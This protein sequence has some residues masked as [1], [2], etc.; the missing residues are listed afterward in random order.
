MN[1]LFAMIFVIA[2]LAMALPPPAHAQEEP[3]EIEESGPRL[4]AEEARRILAEELAPGASHQQQVE[5]YLRRE[6]AAFTVGNAAIRID[7]LRRLVSLTEAP[8]KFSPYLFALWQELW[9]YGNQ[10]EAL[11]IGESLVRHPAATPQ[12]RITYTVLLGRNYVAIGNR[13]RGADLLKKVEA[14]GK[15]LRDTR[16]PHMIA[17]TTIH[18]EDLRATVLH[19]QGDPEG[20]LAAIRRALE[21]SHAEVERSRAAAGSS[22]TDL[23]YDSAIR[24]RNSVMSTAVWLYFAQG[25]NEEAEGTARIG[26]RLAADERTG[27]GTVGLWHRNL[28]QALLG[29][30]RFDEAVAAANEALA[31]LRASGAAESSR[32]IVNTQTCQMQAL[33]GLERWVDADRLATEMRAATADDPKSRAMVDNPILQAFLHLKNNRLG[34]AR[35]RIDG[36]VNYRQ[37]AY[38]ERNASTV[39]ARAVR[40]LVLQAQGAERLALD[41]YRAVFANVFAPERTFGDAQPAGVR[42]FYLPQT[43]RGFLA[44]VRERYAKDGSGIDAELVDLSFRV[45]DRLQL[46]AVQRTLIDSAARVVAATPELQALVRREQEQRIKARETATTLNKA[47]AEDQRLTQEAKQRQAAGKAAKEDEKKLAQEAAEERERAR[48]RQ[49]ALKQL[50]EQLEAVD[51]ERGELQVEIGRRFP[52]YQSLVNPKPPSFGE[53]SKLL[54]KD[55]AFVSLY[56]FEQGTFVWGLGAGGRPAFHVAALGAPEVRD[57]V[58]QL[59]ATLDLSENLDPAKVAFD[60][61]SS[62]RL[63]RELL[64]PVWPALGSPRVVTIA[65][66]GDLGQLPFAVLMTRPPESPFDPARAGWLLRETAVN[67]IATAAAFRAL[68]ESRQRAKPAAA[69]FGFGDPLFKSAAAPASAASRPWKPGRGVIKVGQDSDY[70]AMAALP[71][72]RDEILAIAKALGADPA[73]DA[74]FGAQATRAAAMTTNLSDRRVIAFATHGLRPGDLPGLSRPAL[75][76]AAGAP[77]ESPLLVLDDVLTIKL[78]ADWIVLSA[79]NTAS[80]DGRAQ[81]AFSGLARA[82]FFAGARSALATHWAVES[83]SA[84]QLVTR[85]FAHQAANRD[86]TRAESLRHAQ[87]ELINGQAGA[88]YVHPFFWAPYALYGDPAQ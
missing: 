8:D 64:L 28:A 71:E 46:S 54:A 12:Q 26:L 34:Q 38:G 21:A 82:F 35:E 20:A 19:A 68:R 9:R 7:S 76:M 13:D 73:K 49:D 58:T 81:E 62:H 15:D 14:E 51:K 39:E 48:Q 31:V 69:L 60:A 32:Y 55:E 17:Y 10:T 4:S 41:D 52:E 85:T 22:R 87:L 59:R 45:A 40:A 86:A 61:A 18:T 50:R 72:T 57:L 66:A 43:L 30:R 53:L 75:A 67:Q 1:R 37:R 42:G 25:R 47:L 78:N 56:P 11:E 44:L 88:A 33:L 27:G 74:R 77:G 16:G 79:C 5:Y 23:E 63:Y 6:R 83:L 24:T 29:E 70:G 84:Q 65:T 80:G 3:D 36:V 2:G